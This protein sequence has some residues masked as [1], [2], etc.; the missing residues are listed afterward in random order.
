MTKR[1]DPKD[2]RQATKLV[3]G[4]LNRSEFGETAEAVYLTSGFAYEQAEAAAARFAGEE[5]G[6]TYSRLSKPSI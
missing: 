6:Y 5:D 3:R 2:W 4:G 1:K